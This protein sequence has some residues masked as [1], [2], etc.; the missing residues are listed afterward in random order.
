[1]KIIGHLIIV[2]V[3]I[4]S[5][6]CD[7]KNEIA[8][9]M[10]KAQTFLNEGNFNASIIEF[11]NVLQQDAN[12]QEARYLLGTI[13]VTVG[14]GQS[15]EKE[16]N[17]ALSLGAAPEKVRAPLVKALLLQGKYDE[18]LIL[19]SSVNGAVPEAHKSELQVL[20]GEAYLAKGDVDKAVASYTEAS[21]LNQDNSAAMLGLAK[22][23][24]V[25]GDY[26][27]AETHISSISE[28][29]ENAVD[30][31]LLK[32]EVASKRQQ[33]DEM[34]RLYLKA[35]EISEQRNLRNAAL[36]IRGKL[37]F[38]QLANNKTDE[39]L[40]QIGQLQKAAPDSLFP[41]YLR[42][43]A[44]Y[45]KQEFDV[46][47]E[48]L[49]QVISKA[50]D[51]MPSTLLLGAVHYAKGNFEQANS[52]LTAF[53]NNV[54]THIQARK[55]LGVVRLK[56]NR[57]GEAVE[58]L[59][60]A[61][62]S[63]QDDSALL[64]LIGQAA[65]F[66]GDTGLGIDYLKKA[67]KA[68]PDSS[69]I[70][71]ELAK[72]Y[73]RQ[74]A[75]DSA[76]KELETITGDDADKAKLLL[77][78]THLR[79]EDF[80]SARA[81]VKEMLTQKP[82]S[83]AWW[84][85]SGG[86][87]MIAGNRIKA[88]ADFNKALELK[89]DF[90]Q[91]RLNIAKMEFED[92]RLDEA[93]SQFDKILSGDA[94]NI[95]ALMGMAQVAEQYGETNEALAWIEKARQASE[96]ALV[97]RLILGRYYFKRGDYEKSLAVG[98]EAAQFNQNNVEV[99]R[100]VA[101]SLVQLGRTGEALESYNDI[102]KKDPQNPQWHVELANVYRG[103]KNFAS[104]R[105]ALQKAITLQKDYLPAKAILASID[106]QEDKL[107]DA[108]AMAKRITTD[109]ANSSVGYMLTGD[110]YTKQNKLREAQQAYIK[111]FDVEP[112]L[113]LVNKIFLL[114]EPLKN[115]ET[116]IEIT[117]RWLKDHPQDANSR[118]YLALGYQNVNKP[119]AAEA[120]YKT[121]LE[122]QPDNVMALNNMAYLLI[123]K[124]IKSALE[125]AEKAY[126]K[127]PGNFAI[128]DTYGWILLQSG[129]PDKAIPV[130]K[131]AVEKSN[132]NPSVRYHYAAA[133]VQSGDK[134]GA[135]SILREITESGKSFPEMADASKLLAQ[136]R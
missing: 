132:G 109:H 3:V 20:Q 133:L 25:K 66:S 96:T 100:L 135:K 103:M 83:P 113:V 79:K 60:T 98:R 62:S 85:V 17:L 88:R 31:L 95:S 116:S 21:R 121:V 51:H 55:L 89:N 28:S 42:G 93:K 37:A 70:R 97:P 44:A 115:F 45:Q 29:D 5:V 10:Q 119:A 65:T 26:E 110:V 76:I 35:L 87:E 19:V 63:A 78:Y 15:A 84:T 104:A 56:L 16:L 82:D 2:L 128:M 30:M 4:V 14:N 47:L 129:E 13:Y 101:A 107:D 40:Q 123:G 59:E 11:K 32:A 58:V 117:K 74:G 43:L 112:T 102:I 33:F 53:V 127:V 9:H 106:I 124:D 38:A 125:F 73:L 7:S 86:V 61:V 120:E 18:A 50:P 75:Y 105:S 108:L 67:K 39:A 54:P 22:V 81:T 99:N 41:K 36:N 24:L 92:G 1:M 134:S 34:E 111:G 69:A 90:I 6:G 122:Q 118:M 126:K 12:N 52:Y 48:Y 57:P 136:I 80:A 72:V 131:D 71:A 130:L 114:S 94:K 64:A 27:Q 46:A 8:A 77:V 68:R 91:A 49:Q 23:S